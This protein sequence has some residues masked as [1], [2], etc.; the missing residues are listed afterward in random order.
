MRWKPVTFSSPW[1]LP[2]QQSDLWNDG[3]SLRC[4]IHALC[5]KPVVLGGRHRP[6][7]RGRAAGPASPS[8]ADEEPGVSES[9]AE[10]ARSEPPFRS[11]DSSP[12]T[13][14]SCA[15]RRPRFDTLSDTLR[16]GHGCDFWTRLDPEFANSL[17]KTT[18]LDTSGRRWTAYNVN[19]VLAL[20]LHLER[21]AILPFG[22]D[23]R[24]SRSGSC[25]RS[26]TF[27][28]RRAA[29]PR[30]V[31]PSAVRRPPPCRAVAAGAQHRVGCETA[32]G[33]AAPQGL[34]AAHRLAAPGRR[35]PRAEPE[36]RRRARVPGDR[37]RHAALAEVLV[38][39]HH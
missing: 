21:G 35:H 11:C 10:V 32:H 28:P 16:S 25:V 4:G 15:R 3:L 29:C 24:C 26:R 1:L 33:V 22:V 30:S 6:G 12:I 38:L 14:D 20:F 39:V 23:P 9:A 18:D 19:R 31:C 8:A 13:V 2:G 17:S 37:D 36:R 5:I 7:N 27:G 34:G